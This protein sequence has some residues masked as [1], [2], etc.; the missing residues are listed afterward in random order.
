MGSTFQGKSHHFAAV[1]PS[2]SKRESDQ[3]QSSPSP[4]LST[5]SSGN[6]PKHRQVQT[7]LLSSKRNVWDRI[8]QQ[9][10]LVLMTLEFQYPG[11]SCGRKGLERQAADGT[12]SSTRTTKDSVGFLTWY[13]K[14]ESRTASESN[15]TGD[16]EHRTQ[17][18]CR[19][20]LGEEARSSPGLSE[21][22]FL[23]ILHLTQLLIEEG[24]R[25]RQFGDR[26]G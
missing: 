2:T 8:Q 14:F 13:W 3:G 16:R 26:I 6:R 19:K 18:L 15:G 7:E 23:H 9:V 10:S 4:R 24:G 5:L 22:S 21:D 25:L 11:A 20:A 17:N 1:H 12:R